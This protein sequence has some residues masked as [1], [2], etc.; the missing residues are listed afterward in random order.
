MNDDDILVKD[1]A[2][3]DGEGRRRCLSAELSLLTFVATAAPV[4]SGEVIG[5]AD[6]RV[7]ATRLP[8]LGFGQVTLNG[9][10]I[11]RDVGERPPDRCEH[12]RVIE[13]VVRSSFRVT[14]SASTVMGGRPRAGV[15][16]RVR[17]SDTGDG[18]DTV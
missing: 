15:R 7:S 13:F 2:A 8:V 1:R 18:P 17:A 11:C 9:A 14:S 4:D 10:E 6:S 16:S 5:G 3:G 12:P